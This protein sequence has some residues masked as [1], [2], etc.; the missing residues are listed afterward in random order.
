V[1]GVQGLHVAL[2]SRPVLRGMDFELQRGWTAVVGPNGAGKS[3]LL[4]ALAGLLAPDAG[5]VLVDGRDLHAL[6]PRQRA[7]QIAWMSQQSESGVDLSAHDVVMLG[8]LPHTGLFGT[9]GPADET[10]VADAMRATECAAWQ[11]RRL[12]E[13]SGGERQRVLLARTLAVQ[14]P[15]LLLDEPTTHLDPPH[16]VALVQLMRERGREGVVVSVMHDLPLALHADRILVLDQG[17]V[18]ADGAA[19]SIELHEAI[20]AVFA[21]SLQVIRVGG[22]HVVVPRVQG[23]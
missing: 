20:A 16:Q 2:G 8:R 14:A 5:R 10:A 3:T 11:H 9:P 19:H 23:R 17:V 22:Q 15:V 7:L 12:G 4:R 1:I 6:S 18:R 13:L 21:H